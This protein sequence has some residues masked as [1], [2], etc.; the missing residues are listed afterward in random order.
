MYALVG[1]CHSVL[2]LGGQTM[3]QVG[4]QAE[5]L[6]NML[7]AHATGGGTGTNQEYRQLREIFLSEPRLEAFVPRC[8][9]TCRDLGQFWEFIKHKFAHYHERRIF[10]WDEFRPLIEEAER[11]AG[12]AAD[13]TISTTLDVYDESHVQAAWSKAL[14]RRATDPD[15]AITMA[16][17]LLESVCK[18]ILDDFGEVYDGKIEL[19]KLY[20]QVADK[21]NLS[22]R[23]HNEQVFKQIL[24]GC[25][26]V[27]EGLGSMRNRLGDSHGGGRRQ[28]RPASRHAE[29]AVNLAGAMAAFL[30][31]TLA[32][33][34]EP[35]A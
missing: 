7:V 35:I 27:V 23:Q 15:G 6:Q 30:I 5:A 26:A 11:T 33:R 24:G 9:K 16:R 19:P 2:L 12:Q 25:A 1:T 29:L 17:T 20:K 3:N 14:D 10:L 31:S 8:V 22:P 34:N 28:V 32:T 21:L 13:T 18:H 4:E